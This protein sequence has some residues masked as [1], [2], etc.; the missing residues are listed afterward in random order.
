VLRLRASGGS[1]DCTSTSSQDTHDGAF[2][3]RSF[4]RDDNEA[5]RGIDSSEPMGRWARKVGWATTACGMPMRVPMP[6]S[7]R[8]P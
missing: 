4:P 3:A 5:S 2:A 1:G 6:M 8:I 7:M